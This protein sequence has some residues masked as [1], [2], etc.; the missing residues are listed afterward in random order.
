MNQL[1]IIIPFRDCYIGIQ[2]ILRDTYKKGLDAL[3]A[4]DPSHHKKQM[5]IFTLISKILD[6]S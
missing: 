2:N 6:T 3:D 4:A 1:V 5:V